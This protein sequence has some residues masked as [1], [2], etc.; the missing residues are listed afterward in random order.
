MVETKQLAVLGRLEQQAP[1]HI[2]TMPSNTLWLYLLYV[3]K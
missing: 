2:S 1:M 3:N